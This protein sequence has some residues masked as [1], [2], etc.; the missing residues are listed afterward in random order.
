M[1]WKAD[2]RWTDGRL[3]RRMLTAHAAE[4][5]A[6]FRALLAD[7][8]LSG[9]PCAARL[10][11]AITGKAIYFSRFD[12]E[13][14][15]ETGGRIHPAAPLDLMRTDDGTREASAWTPPTS[16][17]VDWETDERSFAECLRAW[18]KQRGLTRQQQADALRV[19]ITTL[20]GWHAGRDPGQE[21]AMRLLM[22]L[23]DRA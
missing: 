2:L 10:V 3:E 17:A 9:Q 7:E 23:I 5:E 4:A 11:S 20:N 1:P 13:I 18:G 15:D 21:G 6:H 22:T 8:S 14:G 16:P 19:G 12:R